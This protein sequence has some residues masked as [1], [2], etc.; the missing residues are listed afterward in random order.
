MDRS[1]NYFVLS[2]ASRE[3]LFF[4]HF[5]FVHYG[6]TA[7]NAKE[8]QRNAK[9]VAT[10]RSL[11]SHLCVHGALCGESVVGEPNEESLVR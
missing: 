3:A 8:T 11:R 5:G 9:T 2:S 10:S 4:V 7:K 1:L 6:L